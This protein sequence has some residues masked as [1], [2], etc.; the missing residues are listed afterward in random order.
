[1]IKSHDRSYYIGASDTNYVVGSW[2]TKTFDKW[3]GTK[4]GI[5]SQDFMNEYMRAGTAYEHKI[6][7]F[8]NVPGMVMDSQK[9]IG[10]LRVNLDGNTRDTIYE[11]KTYIHENGFKVSKQYLGQA[12]VEMYTYSIRNHYIVSYGLEQEDYNNYYR[13]IDQKRLSFHPVTYDEKFIND[14]YLPRYETLCKCLDKGVWP[15]V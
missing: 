14:I 11:V 10:R 1:M 3:Y 8:L 6:L 7:E 5:Y 15:S 13:D 2:N 12:M 9:V 4:L